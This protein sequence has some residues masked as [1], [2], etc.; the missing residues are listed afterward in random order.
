MLAEVCDLVVAGVFVTFRLNIIITI[1]SVIG[2]SKYHEVL[3]LNIDTDNKLNAKQN[4]DLRE[5]LSYYSAKR[6]V[7]RASN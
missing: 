5:C 3:I 1:N 7:I 4:L 6:N 2:D